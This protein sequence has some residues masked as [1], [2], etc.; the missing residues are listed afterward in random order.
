[1]LLVLLLLVLLQLLP[2]AGRLRQALYTR[3]DLCCCLMEV[4]LVLLLVH[5]WWCILVE[6]DFFKARATPEYWIDAIQ[7]QYTLLQLV[8]IE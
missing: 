2:A 3:T 7:K 4:L 8:M 6:D 5:C 1:V